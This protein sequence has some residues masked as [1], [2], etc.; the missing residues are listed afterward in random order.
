MADDAY[1]V[2]C[3]DCGKT[4]VVTDPAMIDLAKRCNVVARCRKEKTDA[5]ADLPQAR[6][7]NKH[8]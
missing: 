3:G 4:L 5:K 7:G 6:Y 2:V 8:G 1:R